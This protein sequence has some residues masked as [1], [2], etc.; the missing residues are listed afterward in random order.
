M[1]RNINLVRLQKLI[2]QDLRRYFFPQNE[3][4]EEQNKLSEETK[5]KH[6]KCSKN[7]INRGKGHKLHIEK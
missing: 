7:P 1:S 5:E 4:A 2:E 3:Q 6:K